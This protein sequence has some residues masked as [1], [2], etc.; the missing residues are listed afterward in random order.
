MS[1]AEKLKIS[2]IWT[3]TTFQDMWVGG[4]GETLIPPPQNPMSGL[5]SCQVHYSKN[6]AGDKRK[7]RKI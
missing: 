6:N 2:L 1:L 7:A 4:G 3:I 5:L